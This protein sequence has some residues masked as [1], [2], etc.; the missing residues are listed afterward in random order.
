M[1][2]QGNGDQ[3]LVVYAAGTR[4]DG[5]RGTDQQLASAL[6]DGAHVVYV[7]P[8]VS[9]T[10]VLRGVTGWPRSTVTRIGPTLTR[11]SP[12][13][14]PLQ[15]RPFLRAVSTALHR[16]AITGAVRALGRPVDAMVVASL[17]PVMKAVPARMTVLF[18]TDDFVAGARL[19]N[20]SAAWLAERERRQLRRADTVVVVSSVLAE[21]W[22]ALGAEP[23]VVENGCDIR[24]FAECESSEPAA[25]VPADGYAIYV[26]NISSRLDIEV[27][28]VLAQADVPVVL[29]GPV[30][31]EWRTERFRALTELPQVTW[32]GPVPYTEL[33][34]YYGRA[35]VGLLPYVESAFNSASSP[36]KAY[37]YLAAGLPVVASQLPDG[38]AVLRQ[39]VTIAPTQPGFAE[40]TANA[41]ASVPTPAER[42][43]RRAV[44]A[45]CDWSVRAAQFAAAV[46]LPWR[47]ASRG[48]FS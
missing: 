12:V 27:F 17:E 7:D 29:V 46:G 22:R 42:A 45:T 21:R 15:T 4:W 1:H 13:G 25:D 9:L 36:L 44:A 43:S 11:V 14:P 23:H 38:A 32:T 10:N 31:P 19:M 35:R 8:P 37:E 34:R 24:T 16:R 41:V 18:G 48:G 47:V 2:P 28:E 5:L 39:H 26:G 40:A 33:A 20:R 6:A 30:A 3:P